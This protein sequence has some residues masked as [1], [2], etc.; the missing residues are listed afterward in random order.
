MKPSVRLIVFLGMLCS[1]WGFLLNRSYA[2]LIEPTRTLGEEDRK[3]GL[4]SV[5][6][7]PP[8]Q[9]VRLDGEKIGL[10]PI[11]RFEVASG[12]HVLKISDTEAEIYIVPDKSVRLAIFDG[13]LAV[14][15]EKKENSTET[16]EV[17]KEE[18]P[19]SIGRKE[20]LDKIRDLRYDPNYWP[21]NPSGPIY[22]KQKAD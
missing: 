18:I 3:V 19:E 13:E 21:Q 10:T 5:F 12:S 9:E 6:S 20:S 22:P 8:E 15:P 4:L 14:L 17:A 16:T 7:E 1:L 2:E 11:V